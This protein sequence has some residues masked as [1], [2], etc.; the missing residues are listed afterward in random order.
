MK[1]PSRMKLFAEIRSLLEDHVEFSNV[2][3]IKQSTR[4]GP[5]LLIDDLDMI[6]ITMQL[7]DKYGIEI[8]VNYTIE[9]D[10]TAGD[11]TDMVRSRFDA[12]RSRTEPPLGKEQ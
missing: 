1:P 8:D 11:Y 3:V 12:P 4:L 10:V 7:E 2:K 9:P 5:D 6:D